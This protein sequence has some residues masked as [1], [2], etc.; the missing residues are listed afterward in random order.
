MP[1]IKPWWTVS[2]SM[3][4]ASITVTR[5]AHEDKAMDMVKDWVKQYLTLKTKCLNSQKEIKVVFSLDGV[6]W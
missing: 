6:F 3:C 2:L 5:N 4:S 1:T